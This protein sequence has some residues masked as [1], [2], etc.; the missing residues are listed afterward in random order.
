MS[1]VLPLLITTF[2]QVSLINDHPFLWSSLLAA[3]ESQ[4]L[5]EPEHRALTR[6][7][8]G[9]LQTEAV[10]PAAWGRKQMQK[11]RQAKVHSGHCHCPEDGG[12]GFSEEGTARL[13][14]RPYSPAA[15][16]SDWL[17]WQHVLTVRAGNREPRDIC[18]SMSKYHN[19]K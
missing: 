14:T 7:S 3:S 11:L 2:P 9:S 12:G 17:S 10:F 4:F 15:L 16:S 19:P 13:S 8:Q 18:V 1:P 5:A 6:C